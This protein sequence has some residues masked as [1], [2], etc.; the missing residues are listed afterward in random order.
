[1]IEGFLPTL[2]T[3][4]RNGLVDIYVG[5]VHEAAQPADL[6][7]NRLFDNRRVVVGRRGHPLS[8]ARGLAD[9]VD[10]G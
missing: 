5:P 10:A 7:V 8:A 4:L 2:E 6:Q 3:D 1:M 9:L